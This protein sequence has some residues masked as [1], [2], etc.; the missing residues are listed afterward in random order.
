LIETEVSLRKRVET[1][2]LEACI[3][4]HAH[5]N[6]ASLDEIK[7]DAGEQTFER[8]M[9]ARKESMCMARL[10]R[11]RARLGRVGQSVAIEH[12][13]LLEMGRDG[14]GRGEASHPGADDDGLPQNRI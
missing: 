8:A 14:L 6:G 1:R 13:D 10:R 11:A 2:Y 7:L 9:S 3:A 12:D 4:A 5:P